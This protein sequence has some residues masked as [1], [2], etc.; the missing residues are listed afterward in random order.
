MWI[1][2]M[3]G[4]PYLPFGTLN[5]GSIAFV[6]LFEKRIKDEFRIG[7]LDPVLEFILSNPCFTDNPWSANAEGGCT[8]TTTGGCFDA[9]P[10]EINSVYTNFG[11]SYVS[12]S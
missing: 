7:F 3:A 10:P 6:A 12:R 9:F 1:L 8:Y 5:T 11:L 4:A 2:R